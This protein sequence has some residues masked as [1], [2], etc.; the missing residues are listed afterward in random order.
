[1]EVLAWGSLVVAAAAATVFVQQQHKLH[2]AYLKEYNLKDEDSPSP[3][4]YTFYPIL[5]SL[6]CDMI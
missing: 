5:F 2:T 1:V 4:I 6:T 3:L